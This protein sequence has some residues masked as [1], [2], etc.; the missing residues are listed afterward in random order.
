MNATNETSGAPAPEVT[1]RE[2]FRAIYEA[3]LTEA[4][5]RD[6]SP[7]HTGLPLYAYGVAEVPGVVA[8]MI[9]ALALG[10]ANVG[11]VVKATCRALGI[12]PTMT[13]IRAYLNGAAPL[14]CM[15]EDAPPAPAVRFEVLCYRPDEDAPTGARRSERASGP[16]VSRTR[17]AR[18]RRLSAGPF[19]WRSKRYELS[20]DN[21]PHLALLPG[22]E[23]DREAPPSE[24]ELAHL[25]RSYARRYGMTGAEV[26]RLL[27]VPRLDLLF[28]ELDAWRERHGF[29]GYSSGLTWGMLLELI[30]DWR[31]RVIPTF[32]AVRACTLAIFRGAVL[33]ASGISAGRGTVI[34][35]RTVKSG[36]TLA[37]GADAFDAAHLF[38]SLVGPEVARAV[39]ERHASAWG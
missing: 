27:T 38:V 22:E 8:K 31:F 4:V 37:E 20:E 10:Q 29:P 19:A 6:K 30:E 26:R 15:D 5:T 28:R 25:R 18:A 9:P 32:P 3:K 33:Q 2:R 14:A 39:A 12:K 21:D 23:G 35:W 17:T 1:N 13:A 36:E 11:G 7:P 24:A 16:R 34:D